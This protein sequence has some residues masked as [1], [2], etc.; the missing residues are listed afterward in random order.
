[1]SDLKSQLAAA[2]G[3]P[4]PSPAAPAADILAG[5]AHLSDPWL[6]RLRALLSTVEDP[7]ELART[8][9]LGQVRQATDQLMSRLKR[10]GRGR[11][12]RELGALRKDFYARRD[13]A[14][15]SAVKAR[16]QELALSE[17]AYRAL[18]QGGADPGAVLRRLDGAAPDA[19]RGMG[20]RRLREHL[21]G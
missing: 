12:A 1:M 3:M 14:A 2:F 19:L 16:F 17:K 10:A 15:W 21:S 20:A 13:R 6:E 11:E 4:E 7:P 8:P 18:K 5:G 9:K